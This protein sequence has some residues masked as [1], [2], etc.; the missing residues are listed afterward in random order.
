MNHA[1][2]FASTVE[3]VAAATSASN[4]NVLDHL[5]KINHNDK[6]GVSAHRRE[7]LSEIFTKIQNHLD[8]TTEGRNR[9]VNFKTPEELYNLIEFK[10]NDTPMADADVLTTV[11][12]I[13]ENS[14][15][16]NHP[17]FYNQLFAGCDP[18]SMSGDFLT[19]ALN[20][21]MYT[22]EVAPVFLLMEKSF[23]DFLGATVGWEQADGI[24]GPGGSYSNFYGVNLARHHK[25]PQIKKEG[26]ASV[27]PIALLT[28]AESHYSLSKAAALMGMGS[29][30]VH[31]V[32]TDDQGRMCPDA[33]EQAIVDLKNKG[34]D[35]FMINATVGTTVVGAIDPLDAIHEVA[36]KH[37]IWLHVDACLGGPSVWA[38][39]KI[40]LVKGLKDADSIAWDF[41]KHLTIP[42]QSSAITTKHVG[43]LMENNSYGAKY[44]FQAD[45]KS[46]DPSLDSGDKSLQCGRHIDIL[47]TWM[48]FKGK[49]LDFIRQEIEKCIQTAEHL[50]KL[51]E[52]HDNFE[53]LYDVQYIQTCFHYVPPSMQGLPKNEEYY[54]KL[55]TIAPEIK[56]KM[57]ERGSMLIGY[58]TDDRHCN[59]WRMV[60]SN[61]ASSFEDMQEIINEIH[62]LGKDL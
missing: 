25:Y 1:K 28:S 19:S 40:S 48:C 44:L 26:M 43:L 23:I 10:I 60:V 46:Y 27:G 6:V 62:E 20:G 36:K 49:G 56:G 22:Y 57:T 42:L 39:S 13:L 7:F 31:K 59:F 41:H 5:T 58:Q 52:E 4:G 21:S 53:L 17:K 30:S 16:P 15:Q 11:D 2:K 35:P 14:V 29:D 32:K 34:I 12:N 8:K 24:F 3:G 37:D 38:E 50:A 33:L 47:K 54:K 61:P 51:V 55:G 9:V 45:K 18:Y